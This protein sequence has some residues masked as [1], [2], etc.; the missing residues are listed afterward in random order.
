MSEGQVFKGTGNDVRTGPGVSFAGDLAD[1]KTGGQ[2]TDEIT[3]L[4]AKS[5]AALIILCTNA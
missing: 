5:H 1:S 2:T 4:T 3:K